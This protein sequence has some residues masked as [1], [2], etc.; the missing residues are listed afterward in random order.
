MLPTSARRGGRARS[1]SR[2]ERTPARRRAL[3]ASSPLGADRIARIRAGRPPGPGARP[4]ARR[5]PAGTKRSTRRTRGRAGSA[6]PRRRGGRSRAAAR[7]R[8]APPAPPP[9]PPPTA[10][11][12]TPGSRSMRPRP[13]LMQTHKK[14]SPPAARAR[15][16]D[17]T[18]SLGRQPAVL[19]RLREVGVLLVV[20]AAH[21][22]HRAVAL[23]EVEIGDAGGDEEAVRLL[24]VEAQA[25]GVEVAGRDAGGAARVDRE[26]VAVARREE[27]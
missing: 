11:L 6:R 20:L 17:A 10:P 21:A 12:G 9:P 18:A 2:R 3:P 26:G 23:G 19:G 22:R 27:D 8:P 4:Q 14:R 16:Y 13:K 15:F 1:P 25:Q 24:V 7:A 5:A